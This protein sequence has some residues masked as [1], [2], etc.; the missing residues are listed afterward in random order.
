METKKEFLISP[1]LTLK[2]EKGK[3]VIYVAGVKFYQCKFLLIDIPEKGTEYD[4]FSEFSS[5][6]EMAEKLDKSLEPTERKVFIYNF[7][8]ETEFWGHCSNI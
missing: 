5:I 4:Y 2:L 1:Y 8:P 6:D 7:D 3:T